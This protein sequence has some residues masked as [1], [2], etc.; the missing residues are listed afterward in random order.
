MVTTLAL[1]T[2]F[3]L[4]TGPFDHTRKRPSSDEEAQALALKKYTALVSRTPELLISVII[5]IFKRRTGGRKDQ[6]LDPFDWSS[7]ASI[8]RCFLARRSVGSEC[9][10]SRMLVSARKDV[11]VKIWDLKTYKIKSDLPGHTDEVYCVN[12]VSDKVVSGDRDRT[13]KISSEVPLTSLNLFDIF[14]RSLTM[15]PQYGAVRQARV[16]EGKAIEYRA[17]GVQICTASKCAKCMKG[18]QSPSR[19][20]CATGCPYSLDNFCSWKRYHP[21][22]Y[23]RRRVKR[24]FGVPRR[25]GPSTSP[26][27]PLLGPK[28]PA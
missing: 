20:R 27:V 21:D 22:Y 12:F 7:A 2:D 24:V 9:L 8:S 14:T 25:A 11:T 16:T 3:V 10:D 5:C 23:E 4:R 15:G 6:T 26:T 17:K 1:N 13:V 18:K 19:K 28:V